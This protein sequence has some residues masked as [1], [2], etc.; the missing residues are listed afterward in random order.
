M[1]TAQILREMGGDWLECQDAQGIFYH[2]A[3]TKESVD[4]LPA[5]L[6][7]YNGAVAQP[8]MQPQPVVQQLGGSFQPIV[9]PQEQAA[10]LREL[11]NNWLE[12][13]DAQGIFYFNSLTQQSMDTCPPELLA[14]QQPVVMSAPVAAPM[15]APTVAAAAPNPIEGPSTILA[16]LA[17]GWLEC[18]DNLGVY[19]F[20]QFTQLSSDTRPAEAGGLQ[21]SLGQQQPGSPFVVETMAA[22]TAYVSQPIQATVLGGGIQSTL[23]YQPIT[24]TTSFTPAQLPQASSSYAPAYTVPTPQVPQVVAAASYAPPIQPQQQVVQQVVQPQMMQQPQ[25]VRVLQQPQ[26]QVLQLQQPQVPQMQQLP[27]MQQA[28]QMPQMQQFPQLQAAAAAA[29]ARKISGWG[30]WEAYV[31]PRG[32]EF[33]IQVSTGQ[34]FDTPPPAAVQAYQQYKNAGLV[35]P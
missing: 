25:Q 12:C 3:V 20:N 5:E 35:V 26:G 29:G 24:A 22:P 9:Q 6:L 10:V 7:M 30:D 2:N 15:V 27:Q 11:P 1:A 31:D 4:T 8:V 19:Y 13:Q 21:T 34:R 28:P 16:E 14:P 17:N 32:A 23:S 18:R 33:F